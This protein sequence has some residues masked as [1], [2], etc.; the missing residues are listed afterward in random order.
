MKAYW[1]DSERQ[2][3]PRRLKVTVT[4]PWESRH[5]RSVGI[6]AE[7]RKCKARLEC[8]DCTSDEAVDIKNAIDD[9]CDTFIQLA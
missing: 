8:I 5:K 4:P 2:R 6:A 7:I 9:L 1:A 3:T